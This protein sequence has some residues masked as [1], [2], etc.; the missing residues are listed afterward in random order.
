MASWLREEFLA[1]NLEPF[2]GFDFREDFAVRKF[3]RDRTSLRMYCR[4]E[5]CTHVLSTS[6]A[7]ELL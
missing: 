5:G 4:I 7:F 2:W 1:R 6:C 3:V